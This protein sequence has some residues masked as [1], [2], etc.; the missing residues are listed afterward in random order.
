[1]SPPNIIL[2]VLDTFRADRINSYYKD[3]NLT[4]YMV[5]LLD[6]SIYFKNC[7]AVSPWT[8]PSHISMFTGYIR[9]KI[10]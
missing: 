10:I 1:M 9:H 8:L 7:I 5:N 4:P 2:I 3:K 6:N